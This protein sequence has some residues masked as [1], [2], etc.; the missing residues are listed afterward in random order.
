MI[1]FN[2]NKR[3]TAEQTQL[4]HDYIDWVEENFDDAIQEINYNIMKEHLIN[5]H[6]YAEYLHDPKVF[7]RKY[8]AYGILAGLAWKEHNDSLVNKFEIYQELKNIF[9]NFSMKGLIHNLDEILPVANE[10]MENQ[11][12]RQKEEKS[13][14]HS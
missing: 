10:M 1:K 13:D 8:F 4:F 12:N 9:S 6:Q 3:F 11:L 14:E 7:I 5:T 2:P